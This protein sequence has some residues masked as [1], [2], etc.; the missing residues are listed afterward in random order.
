[1]HR[2]P[3][4]TSIGASSKHSVVEGANK[5]VLEL[6]AIKLG[7]KVRPMFRRVTQGSPTF[8]IDIHNHLG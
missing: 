3:T 1:M 4:S 2:I 8:E 7:K 6:P 5:D